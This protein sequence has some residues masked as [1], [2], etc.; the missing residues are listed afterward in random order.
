[1]GKIASLKRF[2]WAQE[3]FSFDNDLHDYFTPCLTI[4]LVTCALAIVLFFKSPLSHD[5]II[6]TWVTY[7]FAFS[8]IIL[9]SFLAIILL[10]FIDGLC[11]P[12]KD[13]PSPVLLLKSYC[14]HMGK[15][16]FIF[17]CIILP[18]LLTAF[19]TSK[20]TIPHV[21][22]FSWD[23]YFALLDRSF[24]GEDAWQ[25]SHSI[26]AKSPTFYLEWFYVVLWSLAMFFSPFLVFLISKSAAKRDQFLMAYCLSWLFCGVILASFLASAGPVFTHLVDPNLAHHFQPLLVSLKEKLSEESTV[27]LS[28]KYLE[29]NFYQGKIT[30]GGGISAMP[31]MHMTLSFL[32]VFFFYKTR[33]FWLSLVFLFLTFLGSV[34]FGYHYAIEAPVSFVMVF[35][36]W[37][38][39]SPVPQRHALQKRC[40]PALSS[41]DQ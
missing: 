39:A 18:L 23:A 26:L 15:K 32:Y 28:Q 36:F 19:T 21:F 11:L 14:S 29:M 35:L 38:I 37:K 17:Q 12:K 31:S 13:L 33:Y 34:H 20:I 5:G 40:D 6:E 4:T 3:R 8:F 41:C 24:L 9:M 16:A 7:S 2:F 30:K 22:G 10:E 1:M 27:L 25:L